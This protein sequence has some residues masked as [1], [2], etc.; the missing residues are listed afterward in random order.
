MIGTPQPYRLSTVRELLLAAFTAEELFRL[1]LYTED[2]GL[3]PLRDEISP[4]DGLATLVDRTITYCEKRAL[5]PNLLAEVQQTNPNQYARF[6][7]QLKIKTRTAEISHSEPTISPPAVV[8]P[9]NLSFDGPTENGQPLGWFNSVGFVS[10]VSTAYEFWVV[11][12]S[13]GKSGSCVLFQNM[14]ATEDEFGSLMQRCPGHYLAGK[15]LRFEGEI[16]T[17]DVQGWAGLWFRADG[18]EVPDLFF[19][20]MSKRPIRGATPWKTYSID[21]LLPKETKW[22]NYGIVLLGPGRMWADN[23]RLMIW[24]RTQ[25]RE[26]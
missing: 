10:R 12:R 18:A 20:N 26:I 19:D 21:A 25:W 7:S 24:D 14:R 11:A 13:D 8:R 5:L 22:I 2:L 16:A 4:A 17:E 1:F 6:E 3:R 9:F 23:F 15:M